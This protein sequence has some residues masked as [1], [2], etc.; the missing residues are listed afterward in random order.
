MTAATSAKESRKED[1]NANP[2]QDILDLETKEETRVATAIATLEEEDRAT[3]KSVEEMAKAEEEQAR[4]AAREEL[5][6][7]EQGELKKILAQVEKDAE[8]E[9][10]HIDTAN[11][12]HASKI[13]ES[14]VQKVLS[15]DF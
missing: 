11:K 12:K 10:G 7:F 6:H 5:A 4:E 3:R 14:L 2:F 13:I 9:E 15:F 8:A 1:I